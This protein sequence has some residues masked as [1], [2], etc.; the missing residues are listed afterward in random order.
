MQIWA[1]F[2]DRIVTIASPSPQ[3]IRNGVRYTQ[4]V[5]ATSDADHPFY[6][7]KF[8]PPT[9]A[10]GRVYLGTFSPD[11]GIRGAQLIVYGILP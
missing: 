4:T 2:A 7:A 5:T 1:V 3:G 9:I 11:G 6:F 8:N 10:N